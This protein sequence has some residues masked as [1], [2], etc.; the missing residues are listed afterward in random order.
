MS[1][2][3]GSPLLV[4]TQLVSASPSP[5]SIQAQSHGRTSVDSLFHLPPVGPAASG[6]RSQTPTSITRG[7]GGSSSPMPSPTATSFK[8]GAG[9]IRDKES[10]TSSSVRTFVP[11]HA[12]SRSSTSDLSRPITT[13]NEDS[14]IYTGS[15]S[16]TSLS[17]FANMTARLNGAAKGNAT[18]TSD[19]ALN[20]NTEMGIGGLGRQGT[21]TQ[22]SVGVTALPASRSAPSPVNVN[23]RGVSATRPSPGSNTSV[24]RSTPSPLHGASSPTATATARLRQVPGANK[25][26]PSVSA[27]PFQ[28]P[29]SQSALGSYARSPASRSTPVVGSVTSLHSNTARPTTIAALS[30]PDIDSD[31]SE[32]S[33]EVD[34]D[35]SDDSKDDAPLQRSA[36]PRPPRPGTS[37]STRTTATAMARSSLPLGADNVGKSGLPRP[38]QSQSTA[39]DTATATGSGNGTTARMSQARSSVM[40]V[41]PLVNLAG[42][43][44]SQ[45][46]RP[47]ASPNSAS[48]TTSFKKPTH[49]NASRSVDALSFPSSPSPPPA[50]R[51]SANALQLHH[52]PQGPF[53]FAAA[54]NGSV[55]RMD[56]TPSP[57]S[58]SIGDS[59]SGKL[60]VTPRDGSELGWNSHAHPNATTRRR[61]NT[62][63]G[64]VSGESTLRPHMAR[65][66]LGNRVGGPT[67]IST[68]K[69]GGHG[70]VKRHSVTFDE[71]GMKDKGVRGILKDT[72]TA[73]IAEDQRMERRRSE[74]RAAIEVC[75]LLPWNSIGC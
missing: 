17:D 57:A 8:S 72:S 44:I 66:E 5:P 10:P 16:Q 64:S 14:N 54:A 46:S 9:G 4:P 71:S 15:T 30:R 50:Q 61:S 60:P 45:T 18:S 33:S 20:E 19:S 56:G 70:H 29:R 40:P 22:R 13:A 23:A 55:L 52:Q 39:A 67:N 59:S 51:H 48:S 63:A 43:T 24:P 7:N 47:A 3:G 28:P 11:G 31:T 1:F 41:A 27:R 65:S 36:Q 49:P 25:L 73:G 35:E 2:G 75:L 26:G 12:R 37:M 6:Q 58:S 34:S 62:M 38:A 68:A 74:A 32:S 42:K 21:I 53:A 69:H